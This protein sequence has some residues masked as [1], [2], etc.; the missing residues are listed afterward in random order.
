MTNLRDIAQIR[1]GYTFRGSLKDASSGN[2]AI[3][4]MKDASK[5]GILQ[6]AAF[7]RTQIDQFSEHYLL[8]PGDLIFRSRGLNTTTILVEQEM[9]RTICI[10]PLMFIRI[11]PEKLV[12]PTY[13]HWYINLNIT[14]LKLNSYARGNS[15]RMISAESME[16]LELVLPPLERQHKIVAAAELNRQILALEAR[17]A[18]KRE[19]YTEETLLQ[20][21]N[22]DEPLPRP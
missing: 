10:A 2:T 1:M 12:L 4:Q 16:G 21:A 6:T 19:R 11:L 13:L 15:I 8:C 5:E 22:G 14:Q 20:F 18:E 9:E 7:A 17:L 3:I